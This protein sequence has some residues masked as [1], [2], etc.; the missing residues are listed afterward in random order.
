[1]CPLRFTGPRGDCDGAGLA[2]GGVGDDLGGHDG[3]SGGSVL[4]GDRRLGGQWVECEVVAPSL[5]P[6]KAG[7]RIKTDRRDAAKLAE[8]YRAGMLS[9]VWMPDTSHEALRDLVRARTAAKKDVTRAK[10]RLTT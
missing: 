7:E 2:G 5:I 1:D 6:K 4:A 8:C 9:P 3:R 10:H